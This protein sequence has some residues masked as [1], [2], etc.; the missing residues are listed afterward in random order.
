M[1]TMLYAGILALIYFKLSLEVIK[2]RRVHQVSLGYGPNNEI[3]QIV[4]AHGNFAAYIPLLLILAFLLEQSGAMPGYVIHILAG[5]FTLGRVLH[6]LAF[7]GDKMKFPFRILGMHM[8][9]WPLVF[10]ALL[11]IAVFFGLNLMG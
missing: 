5:V 4:S 6:F 1:I 11:N 3:A 2:A 10:L 9:L 8:T 7:A